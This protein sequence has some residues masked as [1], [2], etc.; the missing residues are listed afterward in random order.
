MSTEPDELLDGV[1]DADV[2]ADAVEE[3]LDAHPLPVDEAEVARIAA[4]VRARIAE[5]QAPPSRPW[6]LI[7]GLAAAAVILFALASSSPTSQD[8]GADGPNDAPAAVLRAEPEVRVVTVPA[9]RTLAER[10]LQPSEGAVLLSS[11][12]G[13][14]GVLLVQKGGATLDGTDVP[15]SHWAI[16]AHSDAEVVVF[17]DGAPPPAGLPEPVEEQLDDL[18]W[19]ALPPRT[20]DALDRLLEEP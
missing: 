2:L 1:L 12:Q 5:R 11:E 13:S 16:V 7:L 18:R 17:P 8:A 14:T 15:P 4:R 20:M 9:M 19:R 10:P 3:H 6:P